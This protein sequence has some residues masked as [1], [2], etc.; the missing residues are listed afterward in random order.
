M[1]ADV[2]AIH[3]PRPQFIRVVLPR[4]GVP[5][6]LPLPP[7]PRPDGVRAETGSGAVRHRSVEGHSQQ[8]DVERRTLVLEAARVREVR[9]R[10]RAREG[11]IDLGP[12]L[13]E[14]GLRAARGAWRKV[15]HIQERG[16]CLVM[17]AMG[18]GQMGEDYERP[19]E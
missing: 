7:A 10:E 14:P 8:R 6:G 19:Y 2:A 18:A 12:V 17:S 11:L 1:V 5:A 9:E 3:D 16:L 13:L 15:L 4:K